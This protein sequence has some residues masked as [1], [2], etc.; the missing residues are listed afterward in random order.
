MKKKMCFILFIIVF[1]FFVNNISSGETPPYAK[2]ASSWADNWDKVS[3]LDKET[4]NRIWKET[5]PK[6]KNKI[7][8]DIIKKQRGKSTG[9]IGAI[10]SLFG[11][12]KPD[13]S[14]TLT[15]F[16]SADLS[17]D[18]K[19]VLTN[20]KAKLDLGNIPNEVKKIEY[21]EKSFIYSFNNGNKLIMEDGGIDSK[22]KIYGVK[23]FPNLEI[24]FSGSDQAVFVYSNSIYL[25]NGAKVKLDNKVFRYIGGDYGSIKFVSEGQLKVKNVMIEDSSVKINLPSTSIETDVFFKEGDFSKN[26][27]YVQ[28]VY[29]EKK[30]INM[31]GYSITLE[32][33]KPFDKITGNGNNLAIING[34]AKLLFLGDITQGNIKSKD[35]T[36]PIWEIRNLQDQD[37][38][39]SMVMYENG[40]PVNEGGKKSVFVSK[41]L[42]DLSIDD[43]YN[44][45]YVKEVLPKDYFVCV[46][47]CDLSHP[48][49]GKTLNIQANINSKDL[50]DLKQSFPDL[51][52]DEFSKKLEDLPK[53]IRFKVLYSRGITNS[54]FK[55]SVIDESKKLNL[56]DEESNV[57]SNSL[58]RIFSQDVYPPNTAIV[59]DSGTKSATVTVYFPDNTK[60]V[61]ELTDKKEIE[62]FRRYISLR[63][64][65]ESVEK[66]YQSFKELK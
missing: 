10:G 34:D 59:A 57:F 7:L 38:K 1:I 12:S 40:K 62:I 64:N 32:I 54:Q 58:E 35:F 29:G 30:Y 65:K 13:F 49:A 17:F 4:L 63:Y 48:I 18:D 60:S 42:H 46:G 27:Q 39:I 37:N 51:T 28:L 22:N 31:A 33:L 41:Y 3:K 16:D 24:S 21:K 5:D 19:G 14:I 44:P 25:G 61:V 20:G 36:V 15:G 6:L 52:L 53:S 47:D 55:S 43:P 23:N 26:E 45:N 9:F 50:R 2:N 11:A 66:A 56:N 8:E